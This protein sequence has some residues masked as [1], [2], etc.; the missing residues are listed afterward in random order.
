ML[1]PCSLARALLLPNGKV[2][3]F[4]RG[5]LESDKSLMA[6]NSTVLLLF[7][8]LLLVFSLFK[9][10]SPFTVYDPYPIYG[11]QS[12]VKRGNRRQ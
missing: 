3:I 4:S 8:V 11:A 10:S 12:P 1:I 2:K 9:A 6:V 7:C 5:D